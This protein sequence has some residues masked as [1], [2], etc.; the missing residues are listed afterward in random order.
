MR[1]LDF[2]KHASMNLNMIIELAWRESHIIK[3]IIV[4]E[5]IRR[6]LLERIWCKIRDYGW[7]NHQC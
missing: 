3:I 1:S 5:E 6:A 4:K 2:P 7:P